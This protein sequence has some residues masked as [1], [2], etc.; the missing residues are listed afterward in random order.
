MLLIPGNRRRLQT[1]DPLFTKGSGR[2]RPRKAEA[3]VAG[4]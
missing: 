4:I 3:F 1:E 2:G